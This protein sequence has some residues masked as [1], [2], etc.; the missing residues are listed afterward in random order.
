MVAAH[1]YCKL[2]MCHERANMVFLRKIALIGSFKTRER[3]AFVSEAVK[4]FRDHGWIVTSPAGT[5]L[6]VSDIDFVRFDS[7]N[8]HHSDS[9]IQTRTLKKIFD[10]DVVLVIAP[11]GYIG[12]TTCY[13][14]GRIVQARKP[15][16]FTEYPKDLPIHVDECNVISAQE[17]AKSTLDK[18]IHS[19]FEKGTTEA[20]VIERE[21]VD[22]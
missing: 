10:A 12:R 19:L 13:E 20:H 4:L 17:L 11:D 6:L 18:Q 5:S 8:P 21:L 3:Y 15:I 14:I 7:D 22:V 16:L 9:E 2:K 1:H